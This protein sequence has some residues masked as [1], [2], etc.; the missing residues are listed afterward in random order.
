MNEIIVDIRISPDEYIKQYRNPG[1]MVST[2]AR[3]GRTVRFPADILQSFLLHNGIVGSFKIVFDVAGKFK[4][5]ERI[6]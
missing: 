4:R 5:I 1:C 2:R 3:D 6:G